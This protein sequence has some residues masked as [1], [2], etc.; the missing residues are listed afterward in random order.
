MVN[1]RL[2]QCAATPLST[3]SL[4]YISNIICALLGECDL[5]LSHI[6]NFGQ[7]GMPLDLHIRTKIRY[8][9][10][11][12][13][14][15]ALK[16][17]E[18]ILEVA[19]FGTYFLNSVSNADLDQADL[20]GFP[21]LHHAKEGGKEYSF[22][23]VFGPDENITLSAFKDLVSV[24]FHGATE[25]RFQDT[26]G[27]MGSFSGA[28]LARDRS[29]VLDFD[30]LALGQTWQVREDEPKLFQHLRAPQHPHEQCRLPSTGQKEMQRRHRRLGES[31]VTR[32]DAEVACSH[33]SDEG[34]KKACI[35]DVLS[36]GDVDVAHSGGY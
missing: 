34:Q 33:I 23:V 26:V 24:K 28:M 13:T 9:Y 15:A 14:S 18:D 32:E 6:D 11:Y 12:I 30:P 1:H 19:S 3:M 5:V 20:A 4:T 21:I 2:I 8:D 17:G 27:L 31:L 22:H 36:V 29:T 25:E 35:F 10:S 16:V 7:D